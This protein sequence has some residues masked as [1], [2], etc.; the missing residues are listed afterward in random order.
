MEK[1]Y[2]VCIELFEERGYNIIEKDEEQILAL[3]KDGKQIC[4]FISNTPKFNVEKIQEYI[5]L[6]KQ[7]DVFHALIIYKD[8]ATPVAKK[9]IE[10]SN[11]ILIELF[12]EDELRYNITKHYLVPKHELVYEKGTKE[13][14]QFKEKYSDKFP[15]ILK[16]DP[17]SRFYGY[18]KGDIIKITRKGGNIMYR[19]VK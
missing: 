18:N 8:S 1:V 15:I 13:L 9:I 12:Q 11:D 10:E 17:I 3:K 4:A 6:M 2:Q 14:K 16:T 7:I 19:I 5:T